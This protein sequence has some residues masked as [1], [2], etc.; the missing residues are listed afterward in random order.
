MLRDDTPA[1]KEDAKLLLDALTAGGAVEKKKRA[2]GKH[3]T[4]KQLSNKRRRLRQED[5]ADEEQAGE[6]DDEEH[7]DEGQAEEGQAFE[8]VEQPAHARDTGQPSSPWM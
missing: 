5:E 3:L 4:K 1:T 6:H 7:D 2:S 8:P